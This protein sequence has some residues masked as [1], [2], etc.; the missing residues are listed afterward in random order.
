I[1]LGWIAANKECINRLATL[2]RFSDITSALPEQAALADFC[3]QGH[4]EIH[5]KR[6]HKIYRKRMLLAV[7]TLEKKIKNKNVNWIE[8]NGGFTIWMSM[9]NTK[10]SY[11]EINNIFYKNKI[12]LATGRDFFPNPVK[13]KY[14]RLAIASLDEEEILEGIERLSDAVSEIYKR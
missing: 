8:P 3:S 10:L 6:I 14:F 7:Q 5:I 12:R 2:K 11:D 13:D 9:N 4:Y 1:R